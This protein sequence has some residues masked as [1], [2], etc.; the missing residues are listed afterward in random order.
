[1]KS[2]KE[3]SLTSVKIS[4][5][6]FEDFRVTTI[7]SKFSFQKLVERCMYLYITDENFRKQIHEQ[8]NTEY[9]GSL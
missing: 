4:T 2:S 3:Q 9:S 8:I 5:K 1:M 7:R 6:M